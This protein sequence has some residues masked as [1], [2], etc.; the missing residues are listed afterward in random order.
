MANPEQA[1]E[2]SMEEILASIRKII[3][4][5]EEGGDGDATE[6]EAAPDAPPED[7]QDA[8]FEAMDAEGDVF[9]DTDVG[10]N[11][12]AGEGETA[13]ETADALKMVDA[14]DVDA[15]DDAAD[16][17]ILALSEDAILAVDEGEQM[18]DDE[19]ELEDDI[20]FA[21]DQSDAQA[22]A[23][24]VA[25]PEPAKSVPD[26]ELP[27]LDV[28]DR[29]L[30]QATD[31]AVG[32]AFGNLSNVLLSNNAR[33]LDDLVKEILRPMLKAWL[34]ENLPEM[35]ERLV[36]EEIERVSRNRR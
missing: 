23:E 35:V 16:D 29:I 21:D 24:P 7:D 5:D 19:P 15:G 18:A 9:A 10:D 30:S 6:A 1:S 36:R 25:E 11:E 14:E 26:V 31:A 27:A 4:D 2:P 3:S 33:T 17:D 34:D 8:A 22:E 28:E 32:S 12:T 20:S 13:A